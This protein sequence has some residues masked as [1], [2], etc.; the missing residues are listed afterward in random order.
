MGHSH[1]KLRFSQL[2]PAVVQDE[3]SPLPATAL[4]DGAE[5]L[6]KPLRSNST[7]IDC[8]GLRILCHW[9]PVPRT[10]KVLID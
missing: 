1:R 6:N 8:G 2:N 10:K 4:L 9:C 3:A 7:D 5:T